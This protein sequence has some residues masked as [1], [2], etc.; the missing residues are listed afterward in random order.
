MPLSARDHLST[1]AKDAAQV[2]RSVQELTTGLT[3]DQLLWRPVPKKWGVAD[4][5]EHLMAVG[6]AYYPRVRSAVQ[7]GD[8]AGSDHEYRPRLFGRLFIFSA[9]PEGRLPVPAM[10]AFVPPPARPDAPARFHEHQEQLLQLL[11]DAHRADLNRNR[12]TSPLSRF[13]VLTLGECLEMLV[14][15]QERHLGQARR[16]TK[17]DGFPS[18]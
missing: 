12:I 8:R 4:C 14:R 11:R 13:L 9:G 15:H 7:N 10:G 3:P 6:D 1:L 17:V 2:R 5:L 16:V 18:E